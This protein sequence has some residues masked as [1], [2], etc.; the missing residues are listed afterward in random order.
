M[1][2]RSRCH[3]N[4]WS[5]RMSCQLQQLKCLNVLAPKM[6]RNRI[7][8]TSTFTAIQPPW[9]CLI[10]APNIHLF[11]FFGQERVLRHS[12]IE[13][14]NCEMCG[15]R[16][17]KKKNWYLF[18]GR[19][20]VLGMASWSHKLGGLMLV[21]CQNPDPETRNQPNFFPFPHPQ[22]MGYTRGMVGVG[23]EFPHRNR[24]WCFTRCLKGLDGR[25]LKGLSRWRKTEEIKVVLSNA[26]HNFLAY[27]ILLEIIGA[28]NTFIKNAWQGLSSSTGNLQRRLG[29]PSNQILQGKWCNIAI[30]NMEDAEIIR[31]IEQVQYSAFLEIWVYDQLREDFHMKRKPK[32]QRLKVPESI[33]IVIGHRSFVGRLWAS[34]QEEMIW[35]K[36]SFE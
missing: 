17:P 16:H 2:F 24:C 26:F 18:N 15:F 23:F 7:N 29:V 19:W 9:L 33:R 27:T 21:L 31:K 35:F 4:W 30:A 13:L 10:S 20:F 8:S 22:N 12:P 32:S 3:V 25:L 34:T 11:N 6:A 36:N 5:F 1:G 28:S 14:F